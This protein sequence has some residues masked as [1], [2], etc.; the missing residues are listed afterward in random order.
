MQN[1]QIGEVGPRLLAIDPQIVRPAELMLGE[2]CDIGRETRC[3]VIVARR[4][5]SRLHARIVR[6]GGHFVLSDAGSVNGT[7][8]NGRRLDA[9][10][11]LQNDDSIGLGSGPAVLKFI[12]PHAT[13]VPDQLRYDDRLLIFFFRGHALELTPNQ[14]RLLLLLYRNRGRLC[15]RDDCANAVWSQPYNASTHAAALDQLVTTL[16][17][18]LRQVDPNSDLIKTRRGLGYMLE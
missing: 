8:V 15:T 7:Y 10:H 4:E 13:F 12:D 18:R 9:P 16:R 6:N 17:A 14:S 11:T 3:D 5:V 2:T 1:V